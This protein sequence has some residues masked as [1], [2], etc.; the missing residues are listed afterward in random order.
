M[1]DAVFCHMVAE[2]RGWFG[3]DVVLKRA[4]E[5]NWSNY[6]HLKIERRERE[7]K[8]RKKITINKHGPWTWLVANDKPKPI[9]R[10]QPSTLPSYILRN[11]CRSN[12]GVE[13]RNVSIPHNITT[14]EL[15][16]LYPF[17]CCTV[18]LYSS[19]NS[20][21]IGQSTT[22]TRYKYTTDGKWCRGLLIKPI[23]A[24]YYYYS[25]FFKDSL[26]FSHSHS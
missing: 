21:S 5:L 11:V 9:K 19:S 1:V 12:V 2:E 15:E 23:W 16:I 24:L 18:S 10:Q 13:K 4:F 20:R 26:P 8:R 25:F 14:T 7:R 17:P 22:T 6:F 3:T